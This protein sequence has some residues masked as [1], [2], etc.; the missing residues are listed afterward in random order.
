[1]SNPSL[2]ATADE[3]MTC[4]RSLAAIADNAMDY[5]ETRRPIHRESLDRIAQNVETLASLR[6]DSNIYETSRPQGL[7]AYQSEMY[8]LEN[9]LRD[10]LISL[11]YQYPEAPPL[12]EAVK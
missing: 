1:M 9:A 11:G 4:F 12:D 2:P 8:Q 7:D 3:Y 6:G 10:R 5:L